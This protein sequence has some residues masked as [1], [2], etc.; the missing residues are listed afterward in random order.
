ML[1][2]ASPSRLLYTS[3]PIP[4]VT[5]NPPR[6]LPPPIPPAASGRRF[7]KT[8]LEASGFEKCASLL[9]LSTPRLAYCLLVLN[10]EQD[11]IAKIVS[12]VDAVSLC[13][14]KKLC[15]DGQPEI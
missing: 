4:R 6:C 10:G 9:L 11:V 3:L 12:S 14:H 1:E 15:P 8:L 13:L 2:L 7:V 5:A